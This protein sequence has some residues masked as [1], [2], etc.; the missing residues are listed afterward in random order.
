MIIYGSLVNPLIADVAE[1]RFVQ[2]I[3]EVAASVLPYRDLAHMD[4]L[5]NKD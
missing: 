4:S 3:L 2:M 5:G 1:N